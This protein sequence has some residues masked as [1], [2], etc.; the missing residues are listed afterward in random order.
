MKILTNS[1]NSSLIDQYFTTAR[2]AYEEAKATWTTLTSAEKQL[3]ILSPIIAVM[4]ESARNQ[5]YE[6]TKRIYYKSGQGDIS[7]A[8]RHAIWNAYMCRQIS[9]ADAK[10]F[11]TAHEQ[12][13]NAYYNTVFE[14]GY[15]GRQ[16]TNMDL[17]NNEKGR[18]TW[19]VL[20]DSMFFVSDADMEQRVLNKISNGKWLN[21][22]INQEILAIVHSRCH[23]SQV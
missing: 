6:T 3:V 12:K 7:D 8:F 13:D 23:S 11:A 10:A 21:C 4:V 16:H 22:T 14:D 9:K 1:D 5:A 19:S 18:D 20:T 15:T 17:H 2:G